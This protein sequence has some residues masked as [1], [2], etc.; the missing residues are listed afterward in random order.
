MAELVE[1]LEDRKAEPKKFLI[2]AAAGLRRVRWR[3]RSEYVVKGA[4]QK[5]VLITKV[6][7]E[8]RPAN[9]GAVKDLL[10][11]DGVIVSLVN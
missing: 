2:K 11:C 1:M 6:L 10:D 5:L 7:I 9:I 4:H 8:R 3:N